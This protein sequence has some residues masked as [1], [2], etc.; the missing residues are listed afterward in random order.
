MSSA[1]CGLWMKSILDERKQGNSLELRIEFDESR[2]PLYTRGPLV[3]VCDAM[4]TVVFAYDYKGDPY[5]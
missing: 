5:V 2:I 1:Q 3:Y 4:G